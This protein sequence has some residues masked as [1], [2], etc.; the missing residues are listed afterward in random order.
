MHWGFIATFKSPGSTAP[1]KFKDGFGDIP[2]VSAT[3]YQNVAKWR[4]LDSEEQKMAVAKGRTAEGEWL[5]IL[6][7]KK[8]ATARM[9][10]TAQ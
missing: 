4:S 1:L 2:F 9:L 7:C 8:D 3:Y 10:L 6:K 5:H